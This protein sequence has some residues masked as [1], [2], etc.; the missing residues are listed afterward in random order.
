[1]AVQVVLWYNWGSVLN[2]MADKD[3]DP[4]I[5]PGDAPSSS[6]S[7]EKEKRLK[8]DSSKALDQLKSESPLE[9]EDMPESNELQE[10][11][12]KTKNRLQELANVEETAEQETAFA[13]E[14]SGLLDLLREANLS[15]RPLKF[16]CGAILILVLLAGLFFGGKAAWNAWQN[17]PEKPQEEDEAA[18][19]EPSQDD[20]EEAK[21]EY[22]FLDPSLWTGVLLG[23]GTT[24][25]DLGTGVGEQ[26]GEVSEGSSQLIKLASDFARIYEAMQVDVNELLNQ[27]SQRRATLQDYLDELNFS[28]YLGRANVKDMEEQSEA[29]VEEFETLESAKASKEAHFFEELKTLDAYGAQAALENFVAD[30][31]QVVRLRAEYNARQKLLSYYEQVLINMENRISDIEH[32]E[33]ALV[34]GIQVVDIEGSDLNLIIDESQL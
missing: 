17:R 13:D 25:E 3:N 34:Q 6:P 28:L 26:L 14:E 19:K 31:Q 18:Q 22:S 7:D 23:E 12:R 2:P 11:R 20:Q 21:S 10:R 24:E 5:V 15:G 16:C 27:S 9:V 8:R 30:A 4:I 29:L 32:N 33:E 1:M